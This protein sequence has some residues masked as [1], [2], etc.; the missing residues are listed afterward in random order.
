MVALD[1]KRRSGTDTT[2][3]RLPAGYR[4]VN[5]RLRATLSCAA[6][7]SK[8]SRSRVWWGSLT[9]LQGTAAATADLH[10]HAASV[11]PGERLP[12]GRQETVARAGGHGDLEAAGAA[13]RRHI[14]GDGLHQVRSQ[15]TGAQQSRARSRTEPPE[16]GANHERVRHAVFVRHAA[17]IRRRGDGTVSGRASLQYI[18]SSPRWITIT[19]QRGAP[20]SWP[21]G[22]GAGRPL[23][24]S[25]AIRRTPRSRGAPSGT[26][27]TPPR[28]GTCELVPMRRSVPPGSRS[29]ACGRGPS[30]RAPQPASNRSSHMQRR[31]RSETRTGSVSRLAPFALS[32]RVGQADP[33]LDAFLESILDEPA[34]RDEHAVVEQVLRRELERQRE[35]ERLDGDQAHEVELVPRLFL[36]VGEPER[37]GE[38]NGRTGGV[39]EETVAPQAWM[40][41]IERCVHD[42]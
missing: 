32:V 39:V 23:R 12:H 37:A 5:S 2:A 17:T 14:L 40:R 18:S 7:R 11:E 9:T 41:V 15:S 10:P 42:V 21:G 30:R 36:D 29:S 13:G 16:L 19:S 28:W 8:L 24:A 31:A 4:R 33:D 34:L 6:A 25:F 26:S 20:S 27:N 35:A 38:R 1:A 3:T 22:N